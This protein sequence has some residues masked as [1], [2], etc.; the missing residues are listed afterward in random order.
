MQRYSRRLPRR[1]VHSTRHHRPGSVRSQ[2]STAVVPPGRHGSVHRP[3]GVRRAPVERAAQ[4][5][6][7]RRHSDVRIDE[8]P[9]PTAAAQVR[10]EHDSDHWRHF[11]PSVTQV[12]H[13]L[14][15]CNPCI[16]A[17]SAVL[18][19]SL[20]IYAIRRLSGP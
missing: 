1:S 9:V 12:S 10:A 4:T 20:Q 18:P 15:K 3:D 19:L 2:S 8:C 7:R 13:L 17:A 16:T 5:L 14:T 6:V 11:Q